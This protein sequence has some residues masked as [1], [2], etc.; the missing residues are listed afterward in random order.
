MALST[1][2]VQ[3]RDEDRQVLERWARPTSVRAGVGTRAKIVL[4]SE[5]GKGSSAIARRLGVSRPTVIGWRERY[6]SDSIDDL[7]D[8]AGSGRA[9]DHRRRRHR[10]RHVG[11]TWRAPGLTH[12]SSRLLGKEL[13][14]GNATVARAWQRY[15]AQP[16]RRET[17][18][19]STHPQLVAKVKD[20]VGLY[21]DPPEKGIVLCVDQKK[22]DPGL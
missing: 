9:Q 22:P 6:I 14:I 10:G 4:L 12:W 21:L 13:G 19:F 18:K 17:F 1:G 16:W 8:S 5:A 11:R 15:R 2:G 7:A 20:V 3:I